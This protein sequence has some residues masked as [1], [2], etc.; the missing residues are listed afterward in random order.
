MVCRLSRSADDRAVNKVS[1]LGGNW[2][3]STFWSV[4]PQMQQLVRLAICLI[5]VC[6][7]SRNSEYR[8]WMVHRILP[9]LTSTAYNTMLSTL[10]MVEF[11]WSHAA[12]YSE[13]SAS[14]GCAAW[15]GIK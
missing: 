6:L 2:R 7:N 3:A 10:R 12:M 8:R 5:M 15:N 9:K 13:Y 14:P 1:R 11:V 4:E